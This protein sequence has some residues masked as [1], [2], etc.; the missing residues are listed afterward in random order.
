M[1]WKVEFTSKARKQQAK[2][3]AKA[4]EALY[5]L[6]ME[7]EKAGPIRGDWPNYSKLPE[8]AHHCHLKK[9]KP[10]YVAVWKEDK[11]RIRVI[12]VIYAGTHEKAPY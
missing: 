7:I 8:G 4:R 12:E 10:A 6:V 5:V 1:T 2:L 3:P 11:H 9:G